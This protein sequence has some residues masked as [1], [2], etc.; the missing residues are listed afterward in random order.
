MTFITKPL[1]DGKFSPRGQFGIL[2]SPN[3]SIHQIK[4]QDSKEAQF[5]N[6][7]RFDETIFPGGTSVNMEQY[8]DLFYHVEPSLKDASESPNTEQ[9]KEAIK[10]EL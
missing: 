3:R 4:D 2:L 8:V 5:A 10:N 7:V 9:Y 6:Y 1:S